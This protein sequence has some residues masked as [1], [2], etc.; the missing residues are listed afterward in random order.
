MSSG[1]SFVIYGLAFVSAA[2]LATGHCIGHGKKCM[3]NNEL[4]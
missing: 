4:Q 3:H 2:N 1:G